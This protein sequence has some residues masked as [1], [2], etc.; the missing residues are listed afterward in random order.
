MENFPCIHIHTDKLTASSARISLSGLL[1]VAHSNAIDRKKCY[2]TFFPAM[3]AAQQ[4]RW[5]K[6]D[7]KTKLC[8][9]DSNSHI[10]SLWM[11]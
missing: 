5:R 8:V 3:L 11:L 6:K 9:L 4:P 7:E 1:S 2:R 10:I